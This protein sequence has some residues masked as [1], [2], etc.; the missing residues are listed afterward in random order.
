MS[1]SPA[2][3]VR[4]LSKRYPAL[5]WPGRRA[6]RPDALRDLSF[7]LASGEVLALIGPNGSGK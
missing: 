7:E 5:G 2:I 6:D 1:D 3:S 4:G